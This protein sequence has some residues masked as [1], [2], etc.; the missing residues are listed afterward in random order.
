MQG[1]WSDCCDK[2][3]AAEV[4]H[5]KT[6]DSA[7]NARCSMAIHPIRFT[8]LGCFIQHT[9]HQVLN[10]IVV[11]QQQA[12]LVSRCV[13]TPSTWQHLY[14][15]ANAVLSRVADCYNNKVETHIALCGRVY[16]WHVQAGSLQGC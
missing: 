4:C 6:G 5:L 7:L 16:M 2:W 12:I 9:L 13:R 11:L 1:L 8:L 3:Q 15:I 14:N 10:Q